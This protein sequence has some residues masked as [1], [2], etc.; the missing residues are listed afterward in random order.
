MDL[1]MVDEDADDAFVPVKRRQMKRRRLIAVTNVGTTSGDAGK[2]S[3]TP[4]GRQRRHEGI[5]GRKMVVVLMVAI[6]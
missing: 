4:D 5:G 1:G 2:E 6:L 3:L